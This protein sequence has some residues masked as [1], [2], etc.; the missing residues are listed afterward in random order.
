M[1]VRENTKL[2]AVVLKFADVYHV[3]RGL[4]SRSAAV[5]LL[6]S[7]VRIP[8]GEWMFVCCVSML[9]CPV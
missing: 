6:G 4:R 8:L 5:W 9:C 1:Q 2:F 3:L 7:R